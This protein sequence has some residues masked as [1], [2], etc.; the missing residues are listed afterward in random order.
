MTKILDNAIEQAKTLTESRQNQLGEMILD[1]VAQ[2]HSD[3]QLTP[4]QQEEVRRRLRDPNPKFA[5]EEQTEAAFGKFS[6]SL[7]HKELSDSSRL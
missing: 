4:D 1:V 2:D 6:K 7:F 3:V 5:T